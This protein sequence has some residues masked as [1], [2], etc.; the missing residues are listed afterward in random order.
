VT[1]THK[2]YRGFQ[3]GARQLDLALKGAAGRVP[4]Y[5][6]MHE[7]AL[8]E[9]GVGAKEFY[10]NA[11]VLV[12]GS[13][14]ISQRYGID[15][16]FID[17]DVYNIEAEALGQRI[18]YSDE[19]MPDV[20]RGAP[21][22][23]GPDDLRKIR[24]PDFSSEGRF[25][26]VIKAHS[27]YKK[28][29]GVEPSMQFC[30]PFSLAAN[31]RGIEQLVL[32]IYTAPAFAR[33]LFERLTEEVIAPWIAYQLA[34]FPNGSIGGSDAT[35]S[36]PIVNTEILEQW[37]VPYILRLRELC[38]PKVVV[39]NWVGE[40]YLKTPAK[41]TAMLDLKLAVCPRFIEGQDPDVQALGPEFYQDYAERRDVPLILGVGAGFLATASVQEV[42]DRVKH[43]VQ[44]GVKHGRFALYLCNLGATTPPDNVRAAIETA[45]EYGVF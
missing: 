2:D 43:Y 33:T 32:D 18:V 31:I 5:A 23:R 38:G 25:T 14:E 29:T 35:A 45:R 27:L 28:L 17:Y 1:I 9:L 22:I 39:P 40:R 12:P 7:F 44:V 11:D 15:V 20:D 34:R 21:L 3:E 10:T 4:V 16:A 8:R 41:A 36:L 37:V 30:A 24:T 19:H 13:L 42:R 6:Q 26:V